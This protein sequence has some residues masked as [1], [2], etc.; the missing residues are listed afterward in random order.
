MP[1]DHHSPGVSQPLPSPGFPSPPRWGHS[2]EFIPPSSSISPPR[3]LLAG[4][5]EGGCHHSPPVGTCSGHPVPPDRPRG[6]LRARG[7]A[8]N[9]F[10][11]RQRGKMRCQI[12]YREPKTK[13]FGPGQQRHHVPVPPAAPHG[14]P[15][16][17]AALPGTTEPGRGTPAPEPPP[18]RLSE[19]TL[20]PQGLAQP[21]PAPRIAGGPAPTPP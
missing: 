1:Q 20:P 3:R 5:A 13:V 17:E 16:L 21:G 9:L 14:A 6:R 19:G 12:P 18:P 11:C 10:S 2:E 15:G 7:T 4:S 8:G